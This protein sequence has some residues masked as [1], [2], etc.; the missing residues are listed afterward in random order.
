MLGSLPLMAIIVITYNVMAL[1]TGPTMDTSLFEAQLVSGAT[2]TVTV[3]DGL[4]V[5]ALILLFLEMVTATRTSGSTVVNHG[6]SLVV[7]IAALVEFMVLPEFGTST[8]FM[9]TMFTLLDVV[10]GFTITIAT[11]RRDFSVGE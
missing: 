5:L 9:I 11:A 2:W 7:F 1:V 10:A 6:L 4:L 8:F 3:A